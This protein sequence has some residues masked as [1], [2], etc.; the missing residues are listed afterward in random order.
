MSEPKITF[1][2]TVAELKRLGLVAVDDDYPKSAEEA[3]TTM[4]IGPDDENEIDTPDNAYDEDD[5]EDEYDGSVEYDS[6]VVGVNLEEDTGGSTVTIRAFGIDDLIV[7]PVLE[8][9]ARAIAKRIGEPGAFTLCLI[10]NDSED[11]PDEVA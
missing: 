5:I 9:E 7:L 11:I 10:E 8:D 4:T 2:A 6:E 1:T 3:K